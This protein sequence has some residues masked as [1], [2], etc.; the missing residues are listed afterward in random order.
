MTVSVKNL[1]GRSRD[2]ENQKETTHGLVWWTRVASA[3]SRRERTPQHRPFGFYVK[4]FFG[5]AVL[6]EVVGDGV[7]FI[8]R[9]GDAAHMSKTTGP[10]RAVAVPARRL[11]PNGLEIAKE[12]TLVEVR[13]PRV[14][15]KAP[16]HFK[17]PRSYQFKCSGSSRMTM[18]FLSDGM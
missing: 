16:Q 5:R 10:A 1:R 11:G 4:V 12:T 15:L 13:W 18:S 3:P 8:I 2:H 14:A 17:T 7:R 9:V 6:V